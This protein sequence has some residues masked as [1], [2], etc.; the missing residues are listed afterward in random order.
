M[1]LRSQHFG[2]GCGDRASAAIRL[3]TRCCGSQNCLIRRSESLRMTNVV[4]GSQSDGSIGSQTART[5]TFAIGYFWRTRWT[6]EAPRRQPGQVG[7]SNKMTRVRSVPALNAS[8]TGSNE[9]VSSL[10]RGGCAAGARCPRSENPTTAMIA[11]AMITRSDLRQC[12]VIFV[13]REV[14]REPAE[15]RARESQ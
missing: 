8:R 7:E 11:T 4:G 12:L 13:T 5:S 10:A 9:F 2:V 1:P 15:K 6:A 14:L 3:A